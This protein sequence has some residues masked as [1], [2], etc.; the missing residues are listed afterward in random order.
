MNQ[1]FQMSP[2]ASNFQNSLHTLSSHLLVRGW[3]GEEE[4]LFLS[5]SCRGG[6]A[7]P[8]QMDGKQDEFLLLLAT[9]N[10][11]PLRE[12]QKI[13]KLTNI[14]VGQKTKNLWDTVLNFL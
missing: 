3:G 13:L 10:K 14:E 1:V 6:G 12:G 7:P 8:A 9:A 11:R 5:I 4:E 2:F